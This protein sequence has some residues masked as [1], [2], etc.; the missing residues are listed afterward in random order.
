M[1]NK[2]KS[3]TFLYISNEE[4]ELEIRA[5]AQT[6]ALKNEI[7]RYEICSLNARN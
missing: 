2:Q 1:I 4:M 3:L 6:I 7:F 5:N